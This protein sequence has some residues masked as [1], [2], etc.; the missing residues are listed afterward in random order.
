MTCRST[1][2]LVLLAGCWIAVRAEEPRSA[3]ELEWRT[4]KVM[5]VFEKT[6]ESV[7]F[8]HGD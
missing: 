5:G 1:I 8:F 3:G 6:F 7:R 2:A 4:L